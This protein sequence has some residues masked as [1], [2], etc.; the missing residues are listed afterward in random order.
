M[1]KR[2][3]LPGESWDFLALGL[4]LLV[5]AIDHRI[6]TPFLPRHRQLPPQQTTAR[7]LHSP[8]NSN[9]SDLKSKPQKTKKKNQQTIAL[10]R[11]NRRQ[12]RTQRQIDRK[13]KQRYK[14]LKIT[15][16]LCRLELSLCLLMAAE[17]K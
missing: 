12:T 3:K 11:I 9:L 7:P 17:K 8:P 14:R 13:P 15:V 2:I 10:N 4:S 1:T 16:E 5:L 6:Q